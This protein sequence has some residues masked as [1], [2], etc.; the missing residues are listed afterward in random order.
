MSAQARDIGL[1]AHDR[2][3][4][5][6]RTV[7]MRG[8]MMALA[9]LISLSL[10][11]IVSIILVLNAR[12]AVQEE[13]GSAFQLVHEAVV[14]RMPPSYGGRD[15]LAKAISLTEEID[16]LRH[17]TARILDP[18]GQIL[19]FRAQGQIQP[20][21]GAAM[22]LCPDDPARDRDVDPD[23]QLPQCR[24]HHADPCRPHG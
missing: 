7:P 17:V 22:V 5:G 1:G 23:H 16:G 21:F 18:S 2:V 12:Q 11:M 13:I 15:T 14:R 19:R 9:C 20:E 24:R 3:A 8:V 10:C 6:W 4:A